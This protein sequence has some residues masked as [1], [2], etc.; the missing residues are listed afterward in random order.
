MTT[1]PQNP[2][3]SP[4]SPIALSPTEELINDETMLESLPG[5]CKRNMKELTEEE[6]REFIQSVRSN[7]VSHQTFRATQRSQA[8]KEPAKP[9]ASL[10]FLED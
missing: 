10:S 9:S 6:L 5:D 2:T 1:S 7:R 3:S 4:S 8:T